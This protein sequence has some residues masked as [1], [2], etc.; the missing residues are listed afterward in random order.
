MSGAGPSPGPR[1]TWVG[2]ATVVLELEGAR[3]ITDPVLRG[4]VMHLRRVAPP[5]A[6][7]L[8]RDVDAVLISHLHYDHL[9]LPSLRRLGR[10][11][12]VI[13]PRGGGELVR[14][15]G[16]GDVRE[17]TVGETI[18][19]KGADVEVVHAAHDG[20]RRPR[21]AFAEPAGFVVAGDGR[22]VY[23]A[24]DTALFAGME[25]IGRGL[26]VAL[27]PIWGWGPTLGPGH[28]DPQ[29]AAEATALLRPRIAVPIHWG[30]LFPRGLARLRRAALVEPPRA[31]RAQVQHLAP[32]VRVEVLSPGRSL[33]LGRLPSAA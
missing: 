13:V 11:T 5:P 27:L 16:F 1:I 21:G 4:R 22:R 10:R 14:R 19:V 26:D 28:M 24:G 2:H 18:A 33:A 31:F 12:P 15:A 29:E 30:T 32:D 6:P 9:D 7:G 20:H 23:F 3:L 17:V 8:L 25:E